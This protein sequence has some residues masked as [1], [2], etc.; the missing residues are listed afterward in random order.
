MVIAAPRSARG[1]RRSPRKMTARGIA[2]IGAVDESTEAT[3]TP[4]YLTPATNMTEL[5]EVNAPSTAMRTRTAR[6]LSA[7][8]LGAERA[9]GQSAV[10][11]SGRRI[12]CAVTAFF[13]ESGGLTRTVETAQASD[14]SAAVPTPNQNRSSGARSAHGATMSAR[15]ASG[16]SA[17]I[18]R[19]AGQR[20]VERGQPLDNSG[21][22]RRRSYT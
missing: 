16:V 12:A 5:T 7:S 1:V 8:A 20:P 4:A 2:N 22:A 13:S 18:G 9:Q 6:L 3:A 17:I 19:E 21:I 11:A 15:P 10:A 14:A